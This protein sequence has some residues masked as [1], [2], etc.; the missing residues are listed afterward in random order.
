[1][2][3]VF[4]YWAEIVTAIGVITTGVITAFRYFILK[5]LVRLIDERTKQIQPN[6]NGGK[7]LTDLHHRVDTIE[8]RFDG[9]EETQKQILEMVTK[10]KRV[11]RKA[12]EE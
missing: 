12:D 2:D 6:A 9:L 11:G 4:Q 8:S 3:G 7:S 1:M 10:P 5:P